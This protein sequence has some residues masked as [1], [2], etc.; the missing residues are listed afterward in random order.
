M[1]TLAFFVHFISVCNDMFYDYNNKGVYNCS[2]TCECTTGATCN[3][4]SGI[5]QCTNSS[6]CFNI[7]K[8]SNINGKKYVFK[9]SLMNDLIKENYY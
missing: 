6:L 3:K 8:T 2:E 4:Q 9:H 7:M 5:C 1:V